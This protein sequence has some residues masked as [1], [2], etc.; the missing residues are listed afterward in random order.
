MML[1][2]ISQLP[3]EHQRKQNGNVNKKEAF[4]AIENITKVYIS[5]KTM[6]LVGFFPP[7]LWW[8]SPQNGTVNTKKR[9]ISIDCGVR[10]IAKTGLAPQW[11]QK[12]NFS[13]Q[14]WI[15]QRPKLV[16]NLCNFFCPTIGRLCIIFFSV[17]SLR[18][19]CPSRSSVWLISIIIKELLP[20]RNT[21]FSKYTN[22]MVTCYHHDLQTQCYK[23]T[24]KDKEGKR[25]SHGLAKPLHNNWDQG[26]D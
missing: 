10:T 15:N 1:E 8:G 17:G 19:F 14:F 3:S 25:M 21:F 24:K 7:K 2:I 23:S 18:V 4:I 5:I 9:W 16:A 13:L 6:K 11:M 20:C 26:S 12:I 22:S